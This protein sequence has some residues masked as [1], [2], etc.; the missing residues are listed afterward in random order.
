MSF[1]VYG[2]ITIP[3][4]ISIS[5]KSKDT[6]LEKIS[7]ML[8]IKTIELIEA[9]IHTTDNKEHLIVA[10]HCQIKWIEVLD[11]YDI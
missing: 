8:N 5:E 6:A 11:M 4:S 10:D 9:E 2:E 1:T 3:I 7:N